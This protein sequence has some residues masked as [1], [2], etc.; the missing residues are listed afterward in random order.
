M[1]VVASSVL[2]ATGARADAAGDAERAA[3]QIVAAQDRANAAADAWARAQ[4]RLD[5]LNQ[6]LDALAT[7]LA[8]GEQ[9]VAAL[10]A[11]ARQIALLRYT[12]GD[13]SQLAL[14]V[15]S[16][17]LATKVQM[18]VFA[19]IATQ[20]TTDAIDDYSAARDD[21]DAR[22]LRLQRAKEETER[23]S[24]DLV[25]AKGR[26][27]EQI[28]ALANWSRRSCKDARGGRGS[29]RRARPPGGHRGDQSCRG[30]RGD[31]RR[32]SCPHNRAGACGCSLVCRRR[33]AVPAAW[34]AVRRHVR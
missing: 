34:R 12:S 15:D 2:P 7:K 16:D 4:S 17:D 26:L 5:V 10:R 13:G 3:Q 9:Q 23:A 6:D 28:V 22:R 27:D 14:F 21:L 24:A 33:L 20:G 32:Q 30:R 11:G 31:T 1:L 29:R 8:A 25:T 18:R 19:E